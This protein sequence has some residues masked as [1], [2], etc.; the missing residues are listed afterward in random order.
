ME[1]FVISMGKY[2]GAIMSVIALFTLIAWKPYCKFMDKQKKREAAERK[3]QEEFQAKGA[4]G[5]RYDNFGGCLDLGGCWR[6]YN[7]TGCPLHMNI[8][9]EWDTAQTPPNKRSARCIDRIVAKAGTI[10]QR[11]TSLIS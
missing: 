10:S 2:A 6:F 11:T 9:L 5:A 8:S 7:A 1:E 3:A 4:V